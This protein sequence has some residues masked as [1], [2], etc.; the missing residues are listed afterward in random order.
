MK[1]WKKSGL[2]WYGIGLV[3]ALLII[4]GLGKEFNEET[5]KAEV[6]FTTQGITQFRKGMD[7]A[8][9]VKLTYKVDFS[10]YDQIYPT[11]TERDTAKRQAISVIL[12][13]IDNRISA[14]GVSDYSARQQDIDNETFLVVEIGW[15]HSIESA[16]EI[17]GKTVELEFKVP[18]KDTEREKLSGERTTMAQ[19]LFAQIQANPDQLAVLA[20]SKQWE[21]TFYTD[22]IAQDFDTLSNIY[23]P[24]KEK[25]LT[26]QSWSIITTE[27]IY[28]S[29][30]N[31]NGE[32]V[33]GFALLKIES[34]DSKTN[35]TITLDKFSGVAG[36]FWKSFGIATGVSHTDTI[37]SITY[38]ES[39]QS[40]HFNSDMKASSFGGWEW[41]QVLAMSPVSSDEVSAIESALHNSI[42]ITAQEVFVNKNPQW[43]VAVNPKTNEILNGAF[44]SYSAPGVNQFWKSVITINFNEKG[45]EIFCN[46]TKEFVNQQM[47][48]FVGGALQ[49]APVINEPIC[50]GSAQIDGGFTPESAK[51]LS[52]SLNEGALPAPLILSQEEKV[53]P[54]LWEGALE[55][56]YIATVTWLILM[57]FFLL[58]FYGIRQALIGLAVMIIFLIYALGLFKLI[59]YAFSLSGIA[60][61]ILSLGMGVDANIIIY[62]RL[63]EELKE[64][65]SRS[66]AVATAYERSWLAVRDGNVTNIIIFVVLF[67][68][69]MSIFKGFGFAGLITGLLILWVNVPLTRIFLELFKK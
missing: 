38:D 1:K 28:L 2:L 47:A 26:A 39:N 67:G 41:L 59:D 9:W 22:I 34:I 13:N 46:L 49:T 40:L 57:F 31:T 45:R 11:L 36:T 64:G 42:L 44:F 21:D 4:F 43:I 61:I 68:M 29:S 32:A 19:D 20:Q 65:K 23:A 17:I 51:E 10:K 35:E 18:A 53:S 16:K 6:T 37:W 14:L 63:K 54:V 27:W 30:E 50:G 12:K 3:L 33:E 55:G 48:I 15:V 25:I 5:N 24:I 56:A 66:A 62:E 52:D 8:G 60:A 7:I 58:M 69:G